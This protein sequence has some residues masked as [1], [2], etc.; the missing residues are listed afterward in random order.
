MPNSLK[1]NI[2]QLSW[3]NKFD[4][5]FGFGNTPDGVTVLALDEASIKSFITQTIRQSVLDALGEVDVKMEP[6]YFHAYGGASCTEAI[7]EQLKWRDAIDAV[8]KKYL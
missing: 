7:D 5:E 4:K 6:P 3:E 2:S 8:K 1:N